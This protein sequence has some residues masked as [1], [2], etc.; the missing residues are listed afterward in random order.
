MNEFKVIP[1]KGIGPVDLGMTREQVRAVLGAPSHEDAAR[2]KWGISFPA[3]DYVLNNAFQV[4]YDSEMNVEFIEAGSDPAFEVTID[5][6]PVHSSS[7][8]TVLA[9]IREHAEPDES[10][11]EYPTNQLFPDLEL[12]LFREHGERDR[13]DAIG[14][15]VRGYRDDD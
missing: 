5:G 4:S 2:E 3:K 13:F 15:S 10:D 6:V 9:A 12:S 14:I 11:D 1:H 7:P 8:E